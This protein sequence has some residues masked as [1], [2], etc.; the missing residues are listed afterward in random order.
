[1]RFLTASYIINYPLGYFEDRPQY[2]LNNVFFEY[3]VTLPSRRFL[4]SAVWKRPIG[5][6]MYFC[7]GHRPS[8]DGR[9]CLL[10]RGME[11]DGR[12]LDVARRIEEVATSGRQPSDT[13]EY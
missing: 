11:R 7:V 4:S 2:E 8:T 13:R 5:V 1:M 10:P 3:V 9:T 6:V 12:D